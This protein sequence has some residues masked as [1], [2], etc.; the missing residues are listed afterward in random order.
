[1]RDVHG[2]AVFLE[3]A[4]SPSSRKEGGGEVF[5]AMHGRSRMTMDPRIPTMPGWL[6]LSPTKQILLAISAKCRKVFDESHEGQLKEG[7]RVMRRAF[8]IRTSAV[9]V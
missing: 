1:M 6:G 8:M 9:L 7:G 2:S 4:V 5:V 3:A